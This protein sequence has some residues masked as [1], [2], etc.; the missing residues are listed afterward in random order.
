MPQ[1]IQP[2]VEPE[3]RVLFVDDEPNVLSALQ[4][5]LRPLRGEC[6][7]YFA[8][9][10]VQ[11]LDLL[12]AMP[13][14]IVVTDMRMS[15]LDGAA[16]L[17]EVSALQPRAARFVLSGQADSKALLRVVGLAHQYLAKPCDP[18]KLKSTL[19]RVLALRAMRINEAVASSITRLR[20]LPVF[21]AT[22]EEVHRELTSDTP[23]L[24]RMGRIVDR[25]PGA[26]AKLLQIVNSAFF[27][28]HGHVCSAERAVHLL[29]ID[30]L[31]ALLVSSRLIVEMD[32]DVV[33][34]L[35]EEGLSCRS[36]AASAPTRADIGRVV[37]A[38]CFPHAREMPGCTPALAGT[39]LRTLWGLAGENTDAPDAEDR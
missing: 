9:S 25:D 27:G 36:D 29:G 30:L 21:P 34:R 26:T 23:S 11:A 7:P 31:R 28:S 1:Q 22:L 35:D 14:D 18:E 33:T 37:L 4:R 17:D 38:C 10:G 3:R 2:G 19:R 20:A 8:T 15:G 39:Y 5:M 12:A 16:L 13:F 32:P 24:A 6:L